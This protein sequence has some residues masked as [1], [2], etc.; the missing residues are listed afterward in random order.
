M[1]GKPKFSWNTP[2]RYVELLNF[3][4]EVM[5]I[6]ETRVYK[7]NDEE[8]RPVIKNWLGKEGLLL[9]ETFTQ[10]EREKSKIQRDKETILSVK[11]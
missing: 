6:L 9:M 4:Y 3:Q 8:R 10:E 2:G 11:Q 5:T 1:L 7:I